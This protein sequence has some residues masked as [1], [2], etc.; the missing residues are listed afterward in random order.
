M[1]T[2]FS[3]VLVDTSSFLN[4]MPKNIL[5]QILV[6]RAKMRAN[7]LVMRAF[8]GSR[9]QMIGEIDLPIRVGPYL[10]TI[11]FQIMHINSTYSCL[12][13]RP[14]IHAIRPVTSMLHQ[15]MKVT[16]DDKLV[17]ICGK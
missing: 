12:L 5:S 15:N 8:D 3:S 6:E 1:D 10:F 9:R 16:I 14:R 2:R 11:K 7:A 17:I 4:V 13:G